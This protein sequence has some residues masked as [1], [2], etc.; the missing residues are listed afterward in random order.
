MQQQGTLP[1]PVQPGVKRMRLESPPGSVTVSTG[2]AGSSGVTSTPATPTAANAS[3]AA[4]SP[5]S[6]LPASVL[7]P[8]AF[9]SAASPALSGGVPGSPPAAGSSAASGGRSANARGSRGSLLSAE[10]KVQRLLE[11][12]PQSFCQELQ[13]SLVGCGCVVALG[14]RCL[15]CVGVVKQGSSVCGLKTPVCGLK[16]PTCPRPAVHVPAAL[17]RPPLP[18]PTLCSSCLCLQI[19]IASGSPAALWQWLC[20]SVLFSARIKSGAGA[21][22]HGPRSISVRHILLPAASWGGPARPSRAPSPRHVALRR[23]LF[24]DPHPLHLLRPA[25]SSPPPALRSV[26]RLPTAVCRGADH[27]ASGVHGGG[28]ARAQPAGGRRLRPPR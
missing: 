22:Q 20:A 1:P 6:M 25:P 28:R 17:P 21:P 2:A 16:T 8:P 13:V 5:H 11:R 7:C 10:E 12:F 23:L 19:D 14:V 15:G 26:E 4:A 24:A 27:P 18:C 3:T 9:C